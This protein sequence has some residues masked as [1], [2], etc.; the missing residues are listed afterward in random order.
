MTKKHV[1]LITF[2]IWTARQ[3][4]KSIHDESWRFAI[5]LEILISK[6][7]RELA[8]RS[9]CCLSVA[10]LFCK[11][12]TITRI[13]FSKHRIL[14]GICKLYSFRIFC[15]VFIKK[16]KMYH[17]WQRRAYLVWNLQLVV[18]RYGFDIKFYR[19]QIILLLLS[20]SY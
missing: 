11:Y 10:A 1:W 9:Y 16:E 3:A 7:S 5:R 8:T 15:N 19:L 4:A 14:Y 12:V 13:I 20:Y 6:H 2:N 17:K 18:G